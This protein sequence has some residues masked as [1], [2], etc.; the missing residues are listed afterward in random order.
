MRRIK[1]IDTIL[2]ALVLGLAFARVADAQSSDENMKSFLD[3]AVL[4]VTV[5]VNATTETKPTENITMAMIVTGHTE[6]EIKYVNLSVYGFLNGTTKTL[7]ANMSEQGFWLNN[8]SLVYNLTFRVPEQV[9][10]A[11]YGEVT[12]VHSAKYGPITINNDGATW[13]FTMT[14]VR[15]VY[16]EELEKHSESFKQLNQ[17]FWE[18]FGMNLTNESLTGLNQ[19]YLEFQRSRGELE[20]ARQVAVVLGITTFFFVATTVYLVMRKPRDSW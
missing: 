14:N 16:L 9:W 6:V 17:T 5:Q 20:G 18:I 11:T 13:G 2:V 4:G 10:G 8:F 12:L 7:I 3:F 1:A 15:N 19:T